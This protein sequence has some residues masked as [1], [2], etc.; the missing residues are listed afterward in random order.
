[1]QCRC[2]HPHS[3]HWSTIHDAS[4]EWK[5]GWTSACVLH[6]TSTN[7]ACIPSRPAHSHFSSHCHM[8]V[9]ALRSCVVLLIAAQQAHLADNR[10]YR[11]RVHTHEHEH[12][13]HARP[14]SHSRSCSAHSRRMPRPTQGSA[15]TRA[16]TANSGDLPIRHCMPP[17]TVT[18]TDHHHHHPPPQQLPPPPLPPTTNRHHRHTLRTA[19]RRK[20]SVRR[21][22]G[23]W[24][25]TAPSRATCAKAWR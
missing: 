8:Q 5:D 18:T 3:A 20:E 24:C 12:A 13:K 11:E 1:V 21:T 25:R 6:V 17:P 19:G 9:S 15:W 4:S 7:V 16:T 23:T 14:H 2:S 10:H 22:P